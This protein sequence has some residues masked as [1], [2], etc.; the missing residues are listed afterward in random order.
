MVSPKILQIIAHCTNHKIMHHCQIVPLNTNTSSSC[1]IDSSMQFFCKALFFIILVVVV[2][3]CCIF[4]ACALLLW[5]LCYNSNWNFLIKKVFFVSFSGYLDKA[6][7]RPT[8]KACLNISMSWLVGNFC[9]WWIRHTSLPETTITNVF[10][11]SV[12]FGYAFITLS[13]G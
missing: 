6:L 3:V 13:F 8:F 5:F 12:W 7:D 4:I 2:I 1:C 9:L 10:S 11:S